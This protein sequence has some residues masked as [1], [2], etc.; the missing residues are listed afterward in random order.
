MGSESDD[1]ETTT[2]QIRLSSDKKQKWIEYLN[3]D[4]PHGTLTDLIK[5]SV[6]NRIDSKWVLKDK[7]DGDAGDVPE[8]LGNALDNVTERLAAIENRPDERELSHDPEDSDDTLEE[9]ELRRLA[10][11]V[12]DKLPVVNDADHLKSLVRHDSPTLDVQTRPSI[13][14]TAQDSSAGTGCDGA[15]EICLPRRTCACRVGV[16]GFDLKKYIFSRI[17]YTHTT[18]GMGVLTVH[19]NR[20]SARPY[21]RINPLNST[22]NHSSNTP[23]FYGG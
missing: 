5:T 3:S 1:D 19:R 17:N 8:N 13:T 7:Q 10:Y 16:Y 20:L 6:D 11:Q 18:P 4:S 9:H 15:V 21:S 14:G 2:I 12:Y 23:S 22:V